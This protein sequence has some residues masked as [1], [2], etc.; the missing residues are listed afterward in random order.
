M[1]K[2]TAINIGL[3]IKG[4]VIDL[5]VPC[6]VGEEQLRGVIRAALAQ[7]HIHLPESFELHLLDKKTDI[8]PDMRLSH[9]SLGDGDQFAV[10]F[11]RLHDIK[12]RSV[13]T[14]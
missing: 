13:T 3:H 5:R 6:Q 9:Y 14:C 2:T 1:G 10:D 11:E 12:K 7:L 8:Q 4:R